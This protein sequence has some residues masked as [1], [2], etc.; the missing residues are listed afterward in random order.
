MIVGGWVRKKGKL[1]TSHRYNLLPL[2]Y[3]YPGGVGRELVVYD[4]PVANILIFFKELRISFRTEASGPDNHQ[5][6]SEHN[7][8]F[9]RLSLQE[10]CQG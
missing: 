3:S 7:P 5:G 1:D 2:L 4:F 8:R 10:R 9:H 6:M